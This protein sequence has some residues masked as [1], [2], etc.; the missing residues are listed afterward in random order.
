MRIA[1]RWGSIGGTFLAAGLLAAVCAGCAEPGGK[2]VAATS[3]AEFDQMVS[4]AR[5]P[6]LV[7]FYRNGCPACMMIGTT[8]TS[9]SEEY[10]GKAVFVKVERSVADVRRSFYVTGYPT[11]VLLLDGKEYARWL[12]EDSK[13]VYRQ[14]IDRAL[15]EKRV[16]P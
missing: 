1:A 14:T 13:D 8:L 12:A 15:A 2:F 10:D 7:A 16:G 4:K 11:V 5:Q 6:V 3:A 9:L